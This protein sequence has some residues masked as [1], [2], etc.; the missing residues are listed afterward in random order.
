MTPSPLLRDRVI[1]RSVRSQPRLKARNPGL[2]DN[3]FGA[4]LPGWHIL[5]LQGSGKRTY[6]RTPCLRDLAKYAAFSS[7]L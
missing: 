3:I 1:L 6:P 4:V 5:P 7:N 2:R